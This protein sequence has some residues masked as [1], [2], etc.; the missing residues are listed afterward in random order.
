LVILG[1]A[2]NVKAQTAEEISAQISA[3]QTKIAAYQKELLE[4]QARISA[5]QKE[6][7]KLQ[8]EITEL[9]KKQ[10][11]ISWKCPDL[12]ADGQVDIRDITIVSKAANT[13]LG[14]ENY[15]SV[16][17]VDKDNCVTK[18]DI[19]YVNK[20]F[21]KKIQ[22][23]PQCKGVIIV[24]PLA[25]PESECKCPDLDGNGL[26]DM[27]DITIVSKAANTCLGQGNYNSVADVDYDNCVTKADIDYVTKY[28]GKKIAEIIQC[29]PLFRPESEC[30]C[31]DLDGN[32]L[33]D[34]RDITI[35]SKAANTCLGQGNYNSV[36]D[37]DY[38]DC[39]NLA[40]LNYVTKYFGKKIEEIAQCAGAIITHPTLGVTISASPSSGVMPLTGVDLTANVSGT[41]TG[42]INYTFYCNRSDTG[43][44]ITSGWCFKKD[45]VTQ[46]SFTAVDCCNFST[47]GKYTAKVIVERGNLQAESRIDIQVSPKP[48]SEW[49]CPDLNADGQV[50][51]RDVTIAIKA[52][53]TCLGQENYNALADMD[54]DNCI[55]MTD[56]NYILSYFGKKSA[57][58]NQCKKEAMLKSIENTAAS[59]SEVL[60][61]LM[62]EVKRLIGR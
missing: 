11:S 47:T 35:V 8:A 10:A 9:L 19:D 4:I 55:T 51:M 18:A 48:E 17:D 57:D 21:G 39:V 37:V 31:P 20:Y 56:V 61:R 62:E 38:N 58:I 24:K 25:K 26:I 49:K 12:N 1:N 22:D 2:Q 23:I 44:N 5:I 54:Y 46:T 53:N 59:V 45:G 52:T 7:V 50:D 30:K 14:Q 3:L 33:I 16:A 13:C 28:F 42:P 41:A 6:I 43:T 40:D 36:A 60:S 15:N 27:R 32:G 29:V 34:M